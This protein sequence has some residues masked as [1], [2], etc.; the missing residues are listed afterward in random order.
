MAKIV[1][2]KGLPE[3]VDS[4]EVKNFLQARGIQYE[5]WLVPA[6]SKTFTAKQTLSDIEKEELLQ[7]V[8]DKF[9]LLK[10]NEGYTTR[11][12]VV[13]H[14]DV[15]GIK[16]MLAK[17]DKVH[18]HTDVEVRYIIDGSGFFGFLINGEKFLVHVSESDFISIPKDTTHWFYLDEKMRIKAVR[19]FQDMSGWT[20]NYVDET[21]SLE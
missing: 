17:F 12:L 8:N 16:D 1:Q 3:I 15:P 14:P 6:N 5:H 20:P 9:E 13:L 11:D 7:T 21:T 4:L 2:R 10:S 18:F 19:Y